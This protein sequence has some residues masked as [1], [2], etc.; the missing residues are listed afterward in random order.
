MVRHLLVCFLFLALTFCTL[1]FAQTEAQSQALRTS[2]SSIQVVYVVEGGSI[3]T[4][5]I[6]PQTLTATQV[7]SL[8]VNGVTDYAV[9]YP[10]ANDHFL[11]LYS[12]NQLNVA[13][14][15][16][17][18][19]D[20]SGAPQAPATQ[21]LTTPG[22]SGLQVDPTANFVYVTSSSADGLNNNKAVIRR[23]IS[24]PQTGAISQPLTE[25]TYIL[26]NGYGGGTNDCWVY[27]DGF[28]A[29]AT[30]MYDDI[31]CSN[32]EGIFD[33]DYKRTVNQQTGALGPDQQI[34]SWGNDFAGGES[35]RVVN[36]LLFD[37]VV[38]NDW[39]QGI[40]YENI[41]DVGGKA[42][43]L[44]QC[45][46][47][48]LYA[49]GNAGGAKVHPSGQYLFMELG[50]GFQTTTEVDRVDLNQKQIGNTGNSIPL[51]VQQ[52]SPDGTLV[53]AL[54]YAW[55]A[56]FIEIYGFDVST[57]AVTA[58]GAISVPNVLDS[59]FVAERK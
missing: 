27:F 51:Q 58:G 28:N 37:F 49:C 26:P 21:M 15:W 41:Y 50:Q 46:A 24:D 56:Y 25:A 54:K 36:N 44:L 35:V 5:D 7:G 34:Y 45:T 2:S 42:T 13:H 6:D 17:F 23:Y 29:G 57:G 32:H 40:N 43:L 59:Y 10:S 14:L 47:T 1:T 12:R 30:E 38:P 20:A 53:Y 39:Q 11:Y 18:V 8:A 48:M 3:V 16:V 4:Y 33:T 52:F 22:F 19:T 55:P 9:L 31:F